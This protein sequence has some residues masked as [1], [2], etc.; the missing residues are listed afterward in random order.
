MDIRVVLS[1]TAV[2]VVDMS[3]DR[4][5]IRVVLSVTAVLVVDMSAMFVSMAADKVLIRKLVSIISE[6]CRALK[7][8]LRLSISVALDAILPV[9]M[10]KSLDIALT[11]PCRPENCADIPSTVPVNVLIDK[12]LSVID[13]CRGEVT[14][15]RV[16]TRLTPC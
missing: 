2:L 8:V 9:V 7:L 16:V 3:P 6:T 10:L 1:V 13:C 14:E 12:V 15:S 5:D 4:V 11:V